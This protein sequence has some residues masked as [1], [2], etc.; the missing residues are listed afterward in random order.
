M[1]TVITE[2]CVLILINTQ[3]YGI[4]VS[5]SLLPKVMLE[6]S[7]IFHGTWYEHQAGRT[8]STFVGLLYNFL[9]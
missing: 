9:Q 5:L 3:A 2:A 8:D 6:L 1:Q 7:K 4:I